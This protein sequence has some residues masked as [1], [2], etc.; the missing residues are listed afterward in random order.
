MQFGPNC[1]CTAHHTDVIAQA[2][3]YARP[4]CAPVPRARAD[5][6]DT[7]LEQRWGP[8]DVIKHVQGRQGK[9]SFCK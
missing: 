3:K 9:N 2:I 6:Q 8:G 1:P 4:A 5:H 7:P